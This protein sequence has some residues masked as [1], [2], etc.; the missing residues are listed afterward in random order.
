MTKYFVVGE[1]RGMLEKFKRRLAEEGFKFD[2]PKHKV[3]ILGNFLEGG[4]EQYRLFKFIK[5]LDETGKAIVIRGHGEDFYLFREK[6]LSK[7]MKE[8]LAMLNIA[9]ETAHK[10][11]V[12]YVSKLPYYHETKESI[13]VSAGINPNLKDWKDTPKGGLEWNDSMTWMFNDQLYRVRNGDF[14]KMNKKVISGFIDTTA[15]HFFEEHGYLPHYLKKVDDSKRDVIF[16]KDQ[17]VS[18]GGNW[19]DKKRKG[20]VYITEEENE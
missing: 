16:E 18:I 14:K 13:F 15:Y 17:F 6:Y 2:D 4:S 1:L 12:D 3:I 10:E 9:E 5:E 11:I 20:I 8:E 7:Q 19:N